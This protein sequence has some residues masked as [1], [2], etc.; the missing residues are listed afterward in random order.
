MDAFAWR[1]GLQRA[2]NYLYA[3]YIKQLYIH[4]LCEA[5]LK[6]KGELKGLSLFGMH[7]AYIL[8]PRVA[9]LQSRCTKRCSA[10]TP[11]KGDRPLPYAPT[12]KFKRMSEPH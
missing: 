4:E 7:D 11:N 2:V 12:P 6:H 8:V 10:R 9:Y 1:L 5:R 3:L